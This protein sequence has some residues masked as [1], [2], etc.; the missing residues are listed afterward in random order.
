MRILLLFITLLFTACQMPPHLAKQKPSQLAKKSEPP[1]YKAVRTGNINEVKSIVESDAGIDINHAQKENYPILHLA[2]AWKRPEIIKYLISKGANVNLETFDGF[3]PIHLAAESGSIAC[4]KILLE[5]GA[6]VNQ[7]NKNN[8]VYPLASAVPTKN[9]EAIKFLIYNGAKVDVAKGKTIS[10]LS[11]AVRSQ[12][13]E[14]LKLLVEDGQAKDINGAMYW[15]TMYSRLDFAKYLL[16]KGTL[17]LNNADG[18][19]LMEVA[20]TKEL[21][22]LYIKHGAKVK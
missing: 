19:D 18:I 17:D 14:V 16:S 13:F 2:A 6:D 8:S 1:L 15:T 21:K 9:I 11:M 12:S 4:M 3:Y 20:K 5:N 10:P 22:D 7:K